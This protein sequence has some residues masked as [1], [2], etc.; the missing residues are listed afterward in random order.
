M[1]EFVNIQIGT[2]VTNINEKKEMHYSKSVSLKFFAN[3][4]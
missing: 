3:R 1:L 2:F 4:M